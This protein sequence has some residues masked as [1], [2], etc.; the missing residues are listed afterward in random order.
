MKVASTSSVH[1]IMV[2]ESVVEV[3]FGVSLYVGRSR[4]M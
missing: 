1:C 3:V 4:S 2:L